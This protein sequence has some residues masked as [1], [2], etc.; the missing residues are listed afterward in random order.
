MNY[1]QEGGHRVCTQLLNNEQNFFWGQRLAIEERQRKL[2]NNTELQ[3]SLYKQGGKPRKHFAR[4]F[5]HATN[6]ASGDVMGALRT[7]FEGPARQ[8]GATTT[9]DTLEAPF[10]EPAFEFR[11][12]AGREKA[13]HELAC[14]YFEGA[15][16]K[17]GIP[18]VRRTRQVPW[19][20]PSASG[21]MAWASPPPD[22]GVSP[23]DSAS[24]SGGGAALMMP[25][26]AAL[27]L[28]SAR[29]STKSS[30]CGSRSCRHTTA[31]S[32]SVCS[33]RQQRSPAAA[34]GRR[35]PGGPPGSLRSGGAP[36]STPAAPPQT[37]RCAASAASGPSSAATSTTSGGGS[38][39]TGSGGGSRAAASEGE[40]AGV[41][42]NLAAAALGF[43]HGGCRTPLPMSAW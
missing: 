5:P 30:S 8:R 32:S 39:S 28:S 2:A 26:A 9:R 42:V 31:R 43:P 12:D 35:T 27:Q 17:K 16:D 18:R 19:G 15:G 3:A 29:G 25:P 34:R 41:A 1:N 4:G 11:V 40:G 33:S 36:S 14:P 38:R 24:E 22:F 10:V 6:N 37:A 20:P 23:S 21:L 7:G 13:E